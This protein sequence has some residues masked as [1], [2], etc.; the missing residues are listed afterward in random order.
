MFYENVGAEKILG[1]GHTF[2]L[3]RGTMGTVK[4]MGTNFKK[5]HF[6]N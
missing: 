6:V 2:D 4:S 5:C 3:Y 1:V